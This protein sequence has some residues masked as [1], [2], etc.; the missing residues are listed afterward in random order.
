MEKLDKNNN[1]ELPEWDIIQVSGQD[2]LVFLQ[3]LITIDVAKLLPSEGLSFGEN[4]LKLG[5]F[6]TPQGRLLATFWISR[7]IVNQIE[8]FNIWLSKDIAQDF[9]IKLSRYILRSKVKIEYPLQ[10]TAILGEI[11]ENNINL[12]PN[13]QIDLRGFMIRLP[14][15]THQGIN[16]ARTIQITH[17]NIAT[18]FNENLTQLNLWNTLEIESG[19]PRVVAKT[20]GL[21]VPQM[22]NFESIGGIDFKK[23]CYPGQEVVARSQYRGTIKRRLKIAEIKINS[24]E[25]LPKPGDEIF[26]SNDFDQPV[27]IVVLSAQD[28]DLNK[29]LVQVELKLEAIDKTI[30][31]KNESGISDTLIIRDAPYPLLEI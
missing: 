18:K 10:D 15:V 6:C 17:K 19:L 26:S 30:V 20:Q 23:G 11:Y 2:S 3:N 29:A 14:D 16:F 22:I 1:F 28:R 4:H 24:L 5:G 13:P 21:F 9:A 25:N 7:H 12:S 27:G 8:I 31:L